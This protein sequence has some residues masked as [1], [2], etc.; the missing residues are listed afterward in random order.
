MKGDIG[1]ALALIGVA[2]LAEG[3]LIAIVLIGIG[4]LLMKEGHEKVNKHSASDSNILDR[5]YFLR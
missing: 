2:G 3:Q 1:F 5:L 4:A